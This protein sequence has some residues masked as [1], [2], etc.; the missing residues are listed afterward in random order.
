[1]ARLGD[2]YRAAWRVAVI[3]EGW[4]LVHGLV[5]GQGPVEGVR[6][7]HAW[8]ERRIEVDGHPV[9]VVRDVANGKDVELPRALYY[10]VGDVRAEEVARYDAD[11][12]RRRAIKTGHYGPWD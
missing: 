10:A 4:T 6:F 3:E 2:C 1:M 9:W 11:E 8:L 7:G 12:A 5:T